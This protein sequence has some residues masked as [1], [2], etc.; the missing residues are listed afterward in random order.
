MIV[1]AFFFFGISKTST[2]NGEIFYALHNLLIH[3][4]RQISHLFSSQSFVQQFCSWQGK[5][6]KKSSR[7]KLLILNTHP[8]TFGGSFYSSIESKSLHW[9]N[10]NKM[11]IRNNSVLNSVNHVFPQ[12]YTHFLSH[13]VFFKIHFTYMNIQ[14][15]GFSKWILKKKYKRHT[16]LVV[17]RSH[18]PTALFGVWNLKLSITMFSLQHPPV[19]TIAMWYTVNSA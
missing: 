17:S 3:F 13:V 10:I 18:S 4:L 7:N 5:E 15:G 11:Y 14:I 19:W 1:Y 2:Y 12:Y 9:N 8:H 6:K 16:S